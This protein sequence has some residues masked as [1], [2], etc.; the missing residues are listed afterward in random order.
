MIWQYACIKIIYVCCITDTSAV[1]YYEV[2]KSHHDDL[3]T[4]M[5]SSSLSD[6]AHGLRSVNL[7]SENVIHFVNAN[8]VS[9]PNECGIKLLKEIMAFLKISKDTSKKRKAMSNFCTVLRKQK[10]LPLS[11]VASQL[12]D[13][14]GESMHWPVIKFFT[15]CYTL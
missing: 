8:K 3:I 12:S 11:E 4:A 7:V 6:I 13:E 14:L 2:F 1:D 5:V 10:S 15:L 9:E